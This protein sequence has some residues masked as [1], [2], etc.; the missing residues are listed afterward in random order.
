MATVRIVSGSLTATAMNLTIEYN[1]D[2][3]YALVWQEDVTLPRIAVKDVT[4]LPDM[5]A[6]LIAPDA[7]NAINARRKIVD[8]TAPFNAAVT[9]ST[10]FTVAGA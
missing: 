9:N 5:V 2:D 3:A 1:S 10:L 6:K 4:D 8:L 7:A